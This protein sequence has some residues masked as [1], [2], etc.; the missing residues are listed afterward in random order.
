[1]GLFFYTCCFTIN[2]CPCVT[3]D[4]PF[5]LKLILCC[6]WQV[7]V[8]I[9]HLL[10]VNSKQVQNSSH[11]AI[12]RNLVFC[13]RVSSQPTGLNI[14]ARFKVRKMFINFQLF[15]F[16]C[17]FQSELQQRSCL[18]ITNEIVQKKFHQFKYFMDISLSQSQSL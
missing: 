7:V 17:R 1:M 13:L 14:K 2:F 15:P 8:I 11:C 10:S 16:F 9:G 3:N 6:C 4:H 5:G 18:K 12:S